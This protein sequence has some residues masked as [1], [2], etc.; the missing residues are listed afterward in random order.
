MSNA[1][2]Y[3]VRKVRE[4]KGITQEYV[5]ES[6]GVKQNTYSRMETGS[7]KIQDAQLDKI[8]E[9]LGVEREEIESFDEKLVF[10]NC[11]QHNNTI[12]INQTFNNAS[13]DD[14][15]RLYEELLSAKDRIIAQ[16]E[17]RLRDLGEL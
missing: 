8:A 14:I 7:L 16:L 5:A 17:R 3:K 13:S 1:I 9:V 4:L 10:Y 6:L 2:G 12:G 15:K 11:T